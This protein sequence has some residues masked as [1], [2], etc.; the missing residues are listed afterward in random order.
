MIQY[1]SQKMRWTIR[2]ERATYLIGL[3]DRKLHHIGYLPNDEIESL[4]DER[5]L[6][7]ELQPEAE[8]Q[9]NYEGRTKHHGASYTGCG[10]SARAEY[11]SHAI[12]E[13][14]RGGS[15]TLVI[16]SVDEQSGLEIHHH[17]IAYKR[18]S[19]LTRYVTLRNGSDTPIEVQHL[20]S[21]ALYGMPFS[22]SANQI[23]GDRI[24]IYSFPS[25]WCWEGQMRT[26]TAE[27]AGLFHRLS[28]GCWHVESTGSWSSKEYIP[29]FVLEE[30]DSG[31]FWSAQIEHSG[32]WRFEIGAPGFREAGLHVQGGLGNYTYAHWSKT[33]MPG[34]AFASAKASLS[35][36]QGGIDDALNAMHNHR[37]AVLIQRSHADK[38]FPIIFNEWN[39]TRGA[40]RAETIEH[41]LAAL[42]GTGAEV[43]AIDAGWY[44]PYNDNREPEDWFLHAGDWEPHES[45]FPEGIQT[46]ADQIRQAGMMPGIWLEIEVAGAGSK[47]YTDHERLFMTHQTGYV[48]DNG[49]RFLYFG[50]PDTREY[51]TKAFERFIAAGFSYFKIDYNVDCGLGCNNSGDSLGQGLVDNVRSYY[52]WLKELRRNHPDIIIENC[53]SGGNRLDYGMLS[54]TDLASIT[55]Q[56]DW[57]RLSGV[58]Y[59]VSRFI[60][61][62]QMGNWSILNADAEDRV[63]AFALINSMMGR[64]HISGEIEKLSSAQRELLMEAIHYYKKWREILE[65]CQVVHHTPNASLQYTEGWLVLQMHNA[66]ATKLLL[67]AWRLQSDQSDYGV[68]LSGIDTQSSYEV[69]SFPRK[70]QR[71][72]NG[73]ELQEGFQM[74]LDEEYSAVL[75]GFER[76]LS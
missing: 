74:R 37:A 5:I 27:E 42:S 56:S 72:V 44:L 34:E 55:D 20:S 12:S 1:D 6:R 19:A 17:Y 26:M 52:A 36:I 76:R 75:Y 23:P 46:V 43:Y 8:V 57:F 53:S 14:E 11:K 51:A 62:S 64:M 60:H 21:F 68:K 33:L 28:L 47:S 25:S 4:D 38:S 67:G 24:R 66:A 54:H 13:D 7:R 30:A 31:M 18:S 61:P 32:S 22:S 58:F 10:A 29:F 65:D 48:E 45:R 35:C 71:I 50:S 2:N 41:H 69:T 40:V 9:I 15:Q 70:N 63:F 3:K 59:G 16:T 39:S 49:R 73:D